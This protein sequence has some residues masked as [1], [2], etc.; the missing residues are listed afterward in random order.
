VAQELI[1]AHRVLVGGAP[2]ERASRQVAPAEAV[3]VTGPPS[4]F[5][6]RGG[7]KLDA[8]LNAFSL[9]VTGCLLQRG[10]ARV[11]AVDVGRGQLHDRL[12]ADPRV[13]A[14]ER[15]NIRHL[16]PSDLPAAPFDVVVADL[17]FISLR[18]VARSLIGLAAADAD[19]VVLVKPQFEAGRHE[20]DRGR[21]VIR[22]PAVWAAALLG[23][24]AA[25][26]S[27]GATMMGAMVS[28]L[29]GADGNVEFL[30]H[31]VARPAPAGAGLTDRIDAVALAASA[32]PVDPGP[33]APAEPG[34]A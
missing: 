26:E 15:T 33:A 17:S 3:T 21:G 6:G 8:A 11:T 20:A 30:A 9:D 10:A 7:E 1:S 25:M 13:D 4:R 29:R 19:L 18:T 23:A 5:V 31:L 27:E 16:G 34:Q 32:V 24:G 12:R 14:R 22:D 2:A 28:P